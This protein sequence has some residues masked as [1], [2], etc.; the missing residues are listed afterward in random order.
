[1][2]KVLVVFGLFMANADA[3]NVKGMR[4]W[5]SPDSTRVVLDMTGPSQHSIFTLQD[6]HRMVIDL[7]GAALSFDPADLDIKSSLVQ[8]VRT[9]EGDNA[10]RVVLDLKRSVSFKSFELEPYQNYG[11]RLV[12]DLLDENN[13]EEAPKAKT[14]NASGKRDI[15][16]AID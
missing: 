3:A 1:M 9:S 16:V 15:V 5:Q 6:P 13:Q 12:V 11:H 2:L 8:H 7:K 10:V 4:F 14:V